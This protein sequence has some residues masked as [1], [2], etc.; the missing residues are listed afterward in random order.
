MVQTSF[1]AMPSW[2][3]WDFTSRWGSREKLSYCVFISR[4]H[5][6]HTPV[7]RSLSGSFEVLAP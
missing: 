1:I 4:M 7:F 2:W 6:A 5:A 3:G